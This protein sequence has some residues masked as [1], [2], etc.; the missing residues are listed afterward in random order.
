MFQDLCRV[1]PVADGDGAFRDDGPGDVLP[2]LG[3]APAPGGG[4]TPGHDVENIADRILASPRLASA[5]LDDNMPTTHVQNLAE[6]SE[7]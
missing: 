5:F 2:F 7:E 4:G 1:P 6:D 3:L